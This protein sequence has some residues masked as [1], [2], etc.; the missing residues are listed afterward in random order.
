MTPGW[1]KRLFY[2]TLRA[3]MWINGRFYRRWRQP[4]EALRVHLG[5]GK[6]NYIPGWLNVDA[7]VLTARIDL[8]ANLMDPLPFRDNS[9]ELIYSHHVVEHLPDGHLQAHFQDMFRALLPGGGIR[10]G[11]PDAGTACAKFVAGDLNW[12][13]TYPAERRSIGGRFANFIF[14]DGEHLTALSESYL[15]ELA[16]AAGFV[17]VRRM[18]P[19]RE[20]G[21]V[22][23][24]VLDLEYENDFVN[25]HTV[26]IEAC[27]PR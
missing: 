15:R 25:P 13:S 14:C 17:E 27:K 20:S 21:L 22:G 1:L 3:P 7:N 10:I 6:R 23:R 12:F 2:W 8:W 11:G 5:P 9:I 4:A 19:C 24:E 26:I 16:E 18:L